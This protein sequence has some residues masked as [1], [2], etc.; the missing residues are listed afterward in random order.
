MK[1][2]ITIPEHFPM[3][4]EEDIIAA[5]K[6]REKYTLARDLQ[7]KEYNDAILHRL[8]KE[9]EL[10]K[11]GEGEGSNQIKCRKCGNEFMVETSALRLMNC[12]DC[13]S[14]L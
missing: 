14:D 6:R 13:G 10:L 12:P 7:A 9:K 3:L 4:K 11:S 5:D 8:A 2:E 1:P